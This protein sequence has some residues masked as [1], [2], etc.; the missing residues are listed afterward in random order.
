MSEHRSPSNHHAPTASLRKYKTT[1]FQKAYYIPPDAQ[2]SHVTI[3]YVSAR[4]STFFIWRWHIRKLGILWFS[5]MNSRRYNPRTR[6]TQTKQVKRIKLPSINFLKW[7]VLPRTTM[8]R[9]F[10]KT[11]NAHGYPESELIL[12]NSFVQLSLIICN[13]FV[14]IEFVC[15]LNHWSPILISFHL[16]K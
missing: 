4:I 11:R 12:K 15:R 6:H 8:Y 10:C 5:V 14:Q 3:I 7:I 1:K 2:I 9:Y 13:F 16:T